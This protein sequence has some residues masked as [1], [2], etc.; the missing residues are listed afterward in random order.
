MSEMHLDLLLSAT[1]P[2]TIVEVKAKNAFVDYVGGSLFELSSSK[3]DVHELLNRE[4]KSVALICELL[5]HGMLEG[6]EQSG[7]D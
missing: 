2:V 7:K 5:F 3:R 4:W 6:V 1:G